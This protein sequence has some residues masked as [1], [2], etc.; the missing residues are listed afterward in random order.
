MIEIKKVKKRKKNMIKNICI[1]FF[2]GILAFLTTNVYA[3]TKKDCSQYSTKTLAGLS[4]KMRC[5]RGLEPIK[6]VFK[7]MSL[8]KDNT[9]TKIKKECHEH[10][11]KTIAGLIGKM[12]C[13]RK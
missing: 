1:I 3:E 9:E 6:N 4:D 10:T 11:T 2:L 5:K 12:R 13:K 8:R 7:S